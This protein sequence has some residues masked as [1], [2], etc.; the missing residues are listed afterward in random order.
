MRIITAQVIYV[1]RGTR[2]VNKALKKLAKLI[3]VKGTN[4]CTN[5]IAIKL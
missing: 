1:Q 5:I 4:S 2:M 3:Y